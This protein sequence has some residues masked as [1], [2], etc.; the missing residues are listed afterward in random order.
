MCS[1]ERERGIK[2]LFKRERERVE[3]VQE[4][5]RETETGWE[6]REGR[7]II[8]NFFIP[9]VKSRLRGRCAIVREYRSACSSVCLSVRVY[10]SALLSVV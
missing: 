2:C 6:G 1:R 5:N 7:G 3:C 10:R 8:R 4:R 9:C